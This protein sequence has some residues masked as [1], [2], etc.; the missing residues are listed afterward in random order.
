MFRSRK[1]SDMLAKLAALDRVQAVIEF[2]L[3]A[4]VLHANDNFL[5]ALGYRLDEIVGR[6]HA[7]FV[8]P[9]YGQ[10]AEYRAFW[11]RLRRGE[12]QA[13]QFK[14]YAKDGREVW[15][16]AS[17]NPLLD[18]HG[19]VYK[20]VK[21][22]TDITRQKAEDA[23]RAGQIA[24]IRKAQAVIE[25]TLDGVILDAN[26]AFL[27]AVGYR[28]D[29]IKGEHH[30]KFVD[31]ATAASAEY[32]AFWA[33]LKR[34]EY[35]AAQYKRFGKGGR[36]IWIQASYNPIFDASGRPYKVVKF[37]TDVTEQVTLLSRL[38]A[39]IDQNFGE[40]DK[41]LDL[42]N[43]QSSNATG[44]AGAATQNVQAIAAA[45]EELAVSMSQI[46][47]SMS[48]SREATDSA[49][50]HTIAADGFTKRLGDAA[51]S[52]G[53]IVSLIQDIA[54]QINLLALN[55]TIES[56]RAGEAGRGFAVVAQEVKNLA[57][58]AGRATDQISAE[59]AGVQTVANDVVAT[60]GQI[61][62]AVEVMREHVSTTTTAIAEQRSV[63]QEMSSSMHGAAGSVSEISSNIT[64]ISAA[65]AQVNAAV[66]TTREA[67]AVLAR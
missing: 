2:D 54:A 20:I 10:S 21:F 24:A 64:A 55:A 63:T 8:E 11:D 50:E 31:A 38:R 40:I 57:G 28:L 39:M 14:R 45:S 26:D 52:M 37:A 6:H 43:L 27:A 60:L 47:D 49:V 22:A 46:A 42:S 29:E 23:D 12:F 25:F 32:A 19:K 66:S 33:A 3:D 67:A 9:A 53:G 1:T 35:Q 65:V 58:Q 61:R 59:I 4:K 17:Y 48:M 13:A 51:A 5:N 16:E 7:M 44:A 36:E 30:R 15:I 62:E 41:A 56:A 18:E 34:G